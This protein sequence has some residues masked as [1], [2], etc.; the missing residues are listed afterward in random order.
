LNGKKL[1]TE[2]NPNAKWSDYRYSYVLGGKDEKLYVE[3]FDG[4]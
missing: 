4:K 2:A 1:E 3:M